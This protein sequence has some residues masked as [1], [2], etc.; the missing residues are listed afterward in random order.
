VVGGNVM[1]AS[2]VV[3]TVGTNIVGGNVV[4]GLIVGDSVVLQLVLQTAGQKSSIFLPV[5][6]A[7][8]LQCL[9][10]DLSTQEQSFNSSLLNMNVSPFSQFSV[11]ISVGNIVLDD[12]A[13]GNPVDTTI[14]LNDV[15]EFEVDS[16]GNTVHAFGKVHYLENRLVQNSEGLM[17]H[18]LDCLNTTRRPLLDESVGAELGE[19]NGPP[20]GEALGISLGEGLGAEDGLALWDLLKAILLVLQ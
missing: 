8:L 19:L 13:V 4:I 9:F 2:S 18:Y 11:G 5:M 10:L 17:V 1:L 3:V 6:D 14:S 12:A 15:G 7:S 20:D 16:I